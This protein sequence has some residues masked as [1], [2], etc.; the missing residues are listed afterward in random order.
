MTLP[1]M[2]DLRHK[3]LL[4]TLVGCWTAALSLSLLPGRIVAAPPLNVEHSVNYVGSQKCVECHRD[5]YQTY[6]ETTHSRSMESVDPDKEVAPASFEHKL[7]GNLY[8]VLRR[9]GQLIHREIIRGING[10]RLAETDHPIVY[11]IGSGDHGKSYVYQSGPF[12]GQSPLS[13]YEK[14][15][16]WAM[17]PGYDLPYHPGFGRKLNSEC[18]FCHVGNIDRKQG[19]PNVF[20]V[21]EETIGCERCHGPGEMHLQKHRGATV[22]AGPDETIANPGRLPRELSEAICQQCHLQAAGKSVRA[23]KDEWDYRPGLPLTD[24]RIDYQYRLGDDTMRVVGHVEQ[25][26]QSECYKQTETLTCITCH[27]PHHTPSPEDAAQHYRS[28]CLN[29]HQ[30]DSCGKPH[31]ERMQQANNDC[32]ICHMPAKDTEVPHTAFRHH[33]IGIHTE[34]ADDSVAIAG[35]TPVLDTSAL[36]NIESARCQALAKFQVAQAEPDNASF[37]DYGIEAAGTLIQIKNA[38]A[39]DPDADTILALL[40]RSQGQ[41]KIAQDLATG[42]VDEE[43]K[44]TRARIESLRLLA[45]LAYNRGDFNE[46][47]ERYRQLISLQQEP[48]DYFQLGIGEQNRGNSEKAIEAL[49]TAVDLQPTLVNAHRALSTI[50]QSLGRDTDAA[51]HQSLAEQHAARLQQLWESR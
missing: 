39:S 19:N 47:V 37:A 41:P 40:A 23:G 20:S 8:E 38:D 28:I 45:Q 9:D 26:H 51:R 50:F 14:T 1:R 21:L 7:S 30:E 2:L 18:F 4:A 33:R 5:Q 12:F 27:D 3:P 16:T 34:S 44:P 43:L 36:T 22:A 32:S 17:S 13:W 15:E 49:Q 35:L 11:T 6:L 42:V 29:C 25:L 10:Q 48:H 46:S 31:A 24:F